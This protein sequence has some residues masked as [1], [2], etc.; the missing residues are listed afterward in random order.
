MFLHLLLFFLFLHH[1]FP[2]FNSQVGVLWHI[3][4]SNVCFIP[5]L[6]YQGKLH[7]V[8]LLLVLRF[9]LLLVLV[10]H[11]A[12]NLREGNQNFLSLLVEWDSSFFPGL[13]GA[14]LEKGVE[15]RVKGHHLNFLL[16][17]NNPFP[18]HHDLLLLNIFLFFFVIVFNL[19]SL[20]FF[21]ILLLSI[22]VI[23]YELSITVPFLLRFL[24]CLRVFL[25]VTAIICVE[26]NSLCN[27]IWNLIESACP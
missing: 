24:T 3:D 7:F 27:R 10:L 6:G 15:F 5:F 1:P 21:F 16:F 9:Y 18:F 4:G 19:F 8:F 11:F 17:L 22:V 2:C 20:P 23:F 14:F 26:L 12:F 25:F 13:R